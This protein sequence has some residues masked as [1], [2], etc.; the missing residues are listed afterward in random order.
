M[1]GRAMAL[2]RAPRASAETLARLRSYHDYLDTLLRDLPARVSLVRVLPPLMAFADGRAASADRADEVRASLFV[3]SFYVNEWGLERVVPEASGWPP[4]PKRTILLRE[5]DDLTKHFT[6]SAFIAAEAGGPVAAMAGVYKEVRDS[7][8][9]S[10]FSFV[11]LAADRAG[12]RF[13]QR[14]TA[15]AGLVRLASTGDLGEDDFMPAISALPEG[16]PEAEFQ[17]RFGGVGA[18]PYNDMVAEIDRRLDGL[19]VFRDAR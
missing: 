4:L 13:G 19:R 7:R 18:P 9:G 3:L 16:L 6:L 1:P 8:G 17:R 15:D 12:T 14:A 10:G 5:R 11:D 2:P